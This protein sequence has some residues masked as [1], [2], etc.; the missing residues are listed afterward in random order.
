MIKI[1]LKKMKLE[2]FKQFIKENDD[3]VFNNK[4]IAT[5]L[6]SIQSNF[7]IVCKKCGSSKV[8][9]IGDDGIDYGEMTGYCSG[10]NV[11]KCNNCGNA[12]TIYI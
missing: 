5:H 3:N 1:T 7:M 6:S 4:G 12:N 10:A 2:D 11:I 8:E 9:I